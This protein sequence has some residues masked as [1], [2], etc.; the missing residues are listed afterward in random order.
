M[1]QA[2]STL[3]SLGIDPMLKYNNL[4]EEIKKFINTHAPDLCW[5]LMYCDVH[6]ACYQDESAW[7]SVLDPVFTLADEKNIP[8][9]CFVT[10][11]KQ[12]N[13]LQLAG[14]NITVEEKL[15]VT[16]SSIWALERLPYSKRIENR[17]YSIAIKKKELPKHFI[18]LDIDDIPCTL[19]RYDNLSMP[20][21]YPVV[22]IFET[23]SLTE[24]NSN[25]KDIEIKQ[26]N[27][28]KEYNESDSKENSNKTKDTEE[29]NGN[30]IGVGII[31]SN[32]SNEKSIENDETKENLDSLI[33]EELR[34]K[35]DARDNI[36]KSKMGLLNKK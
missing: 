6:T 2:V 25:S 27:I 31:E 18:V 32:D 17:K 15:T 26:N 10:E 23:N 28:S 19:K 3:L 1:K 12:V 35:I 20:V 8:V 36:G 5:Q 7:K 22:P 21:E 29:N 14:F 33:D 24:K 11:E 13:G 34:L 9:W 30:T 16:K 4:I